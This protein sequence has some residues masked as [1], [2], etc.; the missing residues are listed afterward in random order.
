[1]KFFIIKKQNI[2]FSTEYMD[3]VDRNDRLRVRYMG[4]LNLRAHLIKKLPEVY[5]RFFIKNNQIADY[6]DLNQN[7]ATLCLKN[8]LLLNK[9]NIYLNHKK[10]L[11]FNLF[12]IF[13]KSKILKKRKKKDVKNLEHKKAHYFVI[14]L[15]NYLKKKY[16]NEKTATIK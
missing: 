9:F 1:M 11:F 5:L 8:L 3:F 15:S 6:F 14:K 13:F 2:D 10:L 12:K 4:N 16:K 7:N